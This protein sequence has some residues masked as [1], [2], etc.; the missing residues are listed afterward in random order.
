MPT[1]MKQLLRPGSRMADIASSE[2]T[3]VTPATSAN[4]GSGYDAFGLA[5]GLYDVVTCRAIASGLELDIVGEGADDVPRDEKHLVVRSI[6]AAFDVMGVRQPG[7]RVS[8]RNAIPHGRGLGSSSSAT[9]AGVTIA[10]ALTSEADW[11]KDDVLRLAAEIEGHPDNVAACVLGGFAIAWED[12]G[13]VSATRLDVDPSIHPYAFVPS[14]SV[15]TQ[16]ARG[17]LPEQVSHRDAAFNIARASLLVTAL[18]QKPELLLAA[19]E[20]RLH[21]S[22]RAPAMPASIEL[23][24]HLRSVGIPTFVSG[25]GPTVLALHTQPGL[26]A[27]VPPGWRT[28]NLA[29]DVEG[30]RFSTTTTR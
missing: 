11:S 5:L 14:E 3:V 24:A 12:E 23:V 30:A 17:L 28:L 7:L 22:Y 25:A 10:A 4:L 16:K 21:Q 8:C 13:V 19:T 29:V 9:V 2:V 26:I 6:R 18:T 1:S 27:T 15:S 20:D